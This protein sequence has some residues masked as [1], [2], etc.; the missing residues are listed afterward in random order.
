MTTIANT[1]LVICT[2]E[3]QAKHPE[4]FHYTT[5]AAFANIVKS[6]TFWGSH[7]ADMADQKEVLLMRDQLPAAVAPRFEEIVASLN[8]HD[9]RLFKAAG[10]GKGVAKDFVESL[11]DATFL[12]KTGFT[13]LDAF[14]VSFSTHANDGE[15]E[16]EHGL[17]SQWEQYAGP[18]GFCLVFDTSAMA[19]HLGQEMD[20]RYWVRLTLDPVR[21][22]DAPVEELFPELVNASADTLRQF[23]SGVDYPEMAVPEFLAGATLL[24]GADFRREREVRI[25]A[26]PGSKRLRDRAAKE[27]PDDFKVMPLPEI[28]TRPSTTRRYI[29]IFEVLGS[30]LPI[31]RVIVGPSRRQE[32]NAAF[33]RSLVGDVPVS[34]SRCSL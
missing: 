8:R 4:L 24:K 2:V 10:G 14:M 15:F 17:L 16:R 27:H 3:T 26:I 13:A 19:R 33:A 9:R 25:V 30:K 34:C 6:N 32:E 21:Y 28:H 23:L 29:S 1:E 12:S 18:E 31:K 7:Y 22:A 11:Y 5:P 20:L